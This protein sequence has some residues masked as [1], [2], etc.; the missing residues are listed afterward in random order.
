M[1]VQGD[2]GFP[3]TR[4]QR[5]VP[6]MQLQWPGARNTTAFAISPVVVRHMHMHVMSEK[7]YASSANRARSGRAARRPDQAPSGRRDRMRSW[8]RSQAGRA[9]RSLAA[10]ASV[11]RTSFSRR[12]SPVPMAPSRSRSGGGGY[13]SASSR[14]ATSGRRGPLPD[15]TRAAKVTRAGVLGRAQ[16]DAAQLLVVEPATARDAC[17]R[18]LHRHGVGAG[19]WCSVLILNVYACN[20]RLS[21]APLRHPIKL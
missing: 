18:A 1:F 20:R 11:R 8:A 3:S 2:E 4:L 14:P 17:R 5:S 21:R 6:V 10:P 16:A 7:N 13:V 15:L 12:S 19:L 9:W